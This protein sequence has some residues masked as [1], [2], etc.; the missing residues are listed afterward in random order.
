MNAKADFSD[1]TAR[2]LSAM[3]MLAVGLGSLWVGGDVFAVVL[4]IAAGLM[5]WETSRMHCSNPLVPL[6]FGLLVAAALLCLMF[7]PLIWAL[8]SG[9]IAVGAALLGHQKRPLVV[10]AAGAAIVLACAALQYLRSWYG[11]G[12]TFWLILC[13]IATDI[14]GYFAGKLIGGPKLWVRISPKKTWSGTIGGWI[15][16]ALIGLGA[17]QMGL[18][19]IAIVLTSVLIS[20]ASQAGD[21][22]ESAMKRQAGIKDSSQLIPGHGGLLDRFDGL[23]GAG[24]LFAVGLTLGLV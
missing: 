18:G 19:T 1:L 11:L 21:L 7:L 15:G 2:T 23:M 24:L 17:F 3:A 9:A 14:G 4:I 13:V 10:L 8:V 20:V 16:A 6:V 12:W 22:V 5:G